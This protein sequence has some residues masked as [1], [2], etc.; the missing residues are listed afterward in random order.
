MPIKSNK[1]FYPEKVRRVLGPDWKNEVTVLEEA[2][3]QIVDP[4]SFYREFK[5]GIFTRIL[6]ET[7][8]KY[9]KNNWIS[10]SLHQP[11]RKLLAGGVSFDYVT[12]VKYMY[13]THVLAVGLRQKDFYS[14]LLVFSDGDYWSKIGIP[15]SEFGES[16]I[17]FQGAD[18]EEEWYTIL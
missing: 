5:N 13:R 18:K 12:D 10:V 17:G 14:Q 3:A 8:N 9:N 11:F 1:L 2:N 7:P 6:F 16:Y 4:C 15:I